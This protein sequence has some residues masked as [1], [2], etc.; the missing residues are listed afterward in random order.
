MLVDVKRNDILPMKVVS[1]GFAG[2][3]R[4]YPPSIFSE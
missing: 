4:E 3:H 2:W 1:F